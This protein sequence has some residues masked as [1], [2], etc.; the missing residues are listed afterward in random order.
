MSL[1]GSQNAVPPFSLLI[2]TGDKSKESGLKVEETPTIAVF[3]G[4]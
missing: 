4:S 3:I 2:D 1:E